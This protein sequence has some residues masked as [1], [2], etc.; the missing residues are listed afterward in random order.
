MHSIRFLRSQL[1]LTNPTAAVGHLL[2]DVALRPLGTP[3]ARARALSKT[4]RMLCQ[5]HQLRPRLEGKLPT[6]PVIFVSNHMG[7]V[8]PLAICSLVPCSPIAKSEVATWPLIGGLAEQLNVIF[9]ERGN[10]QS[11]A[12]ALQ[13]AMRRLEAGVSI[14]N[15]PEGTTTRGEMRDFRRGIFGI[16]ALMGVVVVPLALSFDD[17]ELCWVDDDNLVG[18]YSRSMIGR[19]HRVD[20]EVGPAM[21][22]GA[23]ESPTEF[24][25]RVR[26]WI[27]TARARRRQ[28]GVDSTYEQVPPVVADWSSVELTR[29][30]SVA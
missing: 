30:A 8:D 5:M 18:H 9:V 1:M 10:H 19:P 25:G 4:C 12:L 23:T 15:F 6:G 26:N 11:A 27:M 14:L 17:P 16:S 2:Q 7:Y 28:A 22:A 24:A 20:I 21:Q 13:T 3:L 29:P